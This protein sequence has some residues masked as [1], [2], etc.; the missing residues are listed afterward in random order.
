MISDLILSTVI[1]KDIIN[2]NNINILIEFY[3]WIQ[4]KT[5]KNII[6]YLVRILIKINLKDLKNHN[7]KIYSFVNDQIN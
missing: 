5:I 7:A 6:K 4:D 3:D 1:I 2:N